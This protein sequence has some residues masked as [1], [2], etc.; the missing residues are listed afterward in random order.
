ML[1]D[2]FTVSAQ[3]INFLVLVWLMK[4]YLYKPILN[5]IDAREQKIAAEHAQAQ[6]KKAEAIK[7]RDEFQKK[8]EAFEQQRT[9]LLS[10]AEADATRL[11]ERLEDEARQ[12]GESLREKYQSTLLRER[13]DLFRSLKQQTQ[14]EVFAI[15]R[16]A[17]GDLASVSLEERLCEV[18]IGRLRELNESGRQIMAD[19]VQTNPVLVRSAFDLNAQQQAAI[20]Q[21]FQE[22]FSC[23]QRLDF[24][25]EPQL[26]S[27]IELT[28]QGQKLAWSISGYLDQLEKGISELLNG[29]QPEMSRKKEPL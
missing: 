28:A 27:G 19:A 26:I 12:A 13:Q 29:N 21:A 4:R 17:L 1:I 9:S 20:Q 25:C 24:K 5:A 3:V 23:S 18:F 11:R 6:K 2:W 15:S 10:Q 16:K 8:N 7:E 22:T 14:Q